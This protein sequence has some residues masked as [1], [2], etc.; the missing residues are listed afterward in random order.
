MPAFS[1]V[2]PS[3]LAGVILPKPVFTFGDHNCN[4]VRESAVQ[5]YFALNAVFTGN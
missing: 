4:A 5:L 2:M 1:G 3:A